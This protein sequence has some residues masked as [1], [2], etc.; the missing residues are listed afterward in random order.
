MPIFFKTGIG[1]DV[2][3][4]RFVVGHIVVDFDVK[5]QIILFWPSSKRVIRP[6]MG[7]M[8]RGRCQKGGVGVLLENM[9][10]LSRTL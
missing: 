1:E 5:L 4:P 6:I 2:N 7:R 8:G 9:F 3:I 10:G